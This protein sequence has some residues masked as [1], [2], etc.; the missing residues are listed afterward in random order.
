MSRFARWGVSAKGQFILLVI[1]L[2]ALETAGR[3]T[4]S[5]LIILRIV[6]VVEFQL[7][8]LQTSL[9]NKRS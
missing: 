5:R 9:L 8:C 2:V 3:A 4:G 6:R 1:L 7:E